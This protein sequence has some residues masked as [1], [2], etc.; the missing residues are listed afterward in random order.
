MDDEALIQAVIRVRNAHL[1]NGSA[2]QVNAVLT[3]EG[4]DVSLQQVKKAA[5]KAAKRGALEKPAA[6]PAPEEVASE[7]KVAKDK[8]AKA[9]AAK[10]AS[11]ELKACETA[12]MDA[13]RRL[14]A[15]KAGDKDEQVT[16]T[17]SVEAFVQ[18]ITARAIA[19]TLEPGDDLVLKHRIE[20]DIAALEWVH[21]AT[22]QGILSLTEVRW[23]LPIDLLHAPPEPTPAA[24]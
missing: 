16:I 18:Q 11:A 19:G 2:A 7:A 17:G 6:R 3:S 10:L 13:Q 8:K 24:Y 15:A 12:M 4:H 20:A 23:H 5:S 14:R 9:V 1:Q 21:L 22:A